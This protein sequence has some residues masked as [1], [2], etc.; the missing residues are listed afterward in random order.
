MFDPSVTIFESTQNQLAESPLWHPMLNTFF[1]V[2]INKKLLLSKKTHNESQL[3]IVNMPDTLS[4]IAW[5][6]EQH[7]LLCTSTGLYKYHINSNTRHLILN[8]ENTLL[9]RRSNDG[10]ADPWGGFW[11]S[12]MDVNAKKGDGKIYRYYKRQLKAVVSDLS[13][14]NGLCFDK[15]RLRGYYCDSLTSCIY[16]LD[17]DEQTGEPCSE[18]RVFY[19]FNNTD[20]DPDGCVTDQ[21]GNLWLAVWGMGC[22]I[23]LSPGGELIKTIKLCAIKPTCTAFGGENAEWLLVTSAFDEAINNTVSEQGAVFKISGIKNGQFEPPVLL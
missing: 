1:W 7:L 2:D 4:A 21:L 14:P 23:C 22:V 10:R 6:D 3:K 16:V 11:F 18:P 13:I 5:I 20:V 12:T 17:L 9:N 15:A 19:Q 8:I